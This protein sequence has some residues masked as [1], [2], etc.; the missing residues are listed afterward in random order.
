VKQSKSL[1]RPDSLGPF[2]YFSRGRSATRGLGR[3][4]TLPSICCDAP[5]NW[6]AKYMRGVTC[7]WIAAAGF[8]D[9]VGIANLRIGRM[10]AVRGSLQLVTF[11]A[12]RPI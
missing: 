6:H 11:C 8:D 5:A 2:R 1:A 7:Y 12:G 10:Y 9:S 3:Q 4:L